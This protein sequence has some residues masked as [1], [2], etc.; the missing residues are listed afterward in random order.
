M[1]SRAIP[2][3]LIAAVGTTLLGAIYVIAFTLSSDPYRLFPHLID[4]KTSG[5]PNLFYHLRLH[6]PY[7]IERLK[8]QSIVVGSSRAARLGPEKLEPVNSHG[9]NASLPGASMEEMRRMVE[10]AQ[11]TTRLKHVIIGLD[12]Y[13]FTPGTDKESSLLVEDRFLKPDISL[14]ETARH[15]FQN[16]EDNWRALL[17]IDSLVDSVRAR[18][19][20]RDSVQLFREDGTWEIQSGSLTPA[21][22]YSSLAK[23]VYQE[24]KHSSREFDFTEFVALV[25][26]LQ[27]ENI[28]AKLLIT[29][30]N[31]LLL[32]TVNMAGAWD[33][34][35]NWQR[36][37]V[38]LV[39][40]YGTK[41]SIYGLENNP[42][43]LLENVETNDPLFRDGVHLTRRASSEIFECLNT[44]CSPELNPIKLE[45]SGIA[46][47]FLE[48][49]H[50]RDRYLKENRKYSRKLIRWLSN[51]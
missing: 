43:L 39:S 42:A 40:G 51:G 20:E 4:A 41:I 8:P 31:G 3:Y 47:Y 10:H 30:M 22:L 48:M 21:W 32:E 11:A 50:L 6:K 36:Q 14:W 26:F 19:S 25:E 5:T 2:S 17:S 27:A 45:P 49:N 28:E 35:V 37:L 46:T 38:H 24:M 33:S 16:V 23:Q 29:P 1:Q 13:M 15:Y 44:I 34:Y 18:T 7:A 12:Y 9:Y